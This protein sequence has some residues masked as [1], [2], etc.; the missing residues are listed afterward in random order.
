MANNSFWNEASR[1]GA[2]LGVVGV[3]FSLIGMAVPSLA[4]VAGLANTVA[5][6]YLLFYYTRRRAQR[7]T[8]EGYTY[9]QCLGFIVSMGI[10]AGI[11]AGAY[12]IVASNFLFPET[13][14]QSLNTT[15]STLQQSGVYNNEMMDQMSSMMRTYIFSPI[16]ALISS[17]VGSVLTFGFYGLFISIGTKCEPDIFDSNNTDEEDE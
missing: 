3:A 2:V 12:Q 7:F 13:F 5:T 14:E 9:S 11:I 10:F 4:F 17:V 15:L 16:P 8:S 6:I 1:Y